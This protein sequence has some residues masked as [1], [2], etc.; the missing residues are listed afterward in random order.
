MKSGGAPLS[1]GWKGKPDMVGRFFRPYRHLTY[2][3]SINRIILDRTT[4]SGL[5][6]VHLHHRADAP[7]DEFFVA[8]TF[9]AGAAARGDFEHRVEDLL[10]RLLYRR[11]AIR[12][13][14]GVD[15][16][17]VRHGAERVAVGG[18]LDH[19]DG[20]EADGAA[21]S[22]GEGDQVAS[23]GGETGQ[24]HRVVAR[25]IHIGEASG[26]DPLGIFV[27]VDERAGAALG[28]RAQ[29]LFDNVAQAALFVAGR[30]VV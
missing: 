3:E 13:G 6:P 14:A 11:F 29:T 27:N 25:R 19:R 7:G 24:A 8:Q 28:H 15:V 5:V 21:A 12:N 2:L 22:G 18:D 30:R 26:G 1:P 23:A 4:L 9:G 16:H 20:R 17:V 10:A